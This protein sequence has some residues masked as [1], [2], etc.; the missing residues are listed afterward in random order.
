[1]CAWLDPSGQA[2]GCYTPEGGGEVNLAGGR[3]QAEALDSVA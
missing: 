3:P 1:M 2:R